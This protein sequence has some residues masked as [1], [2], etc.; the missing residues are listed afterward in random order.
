MAADLFNLISLTADDSLPESS[1]IVW[2][3]VTSNDKTKEPQ[4]DNIMP[5]I[6]PR[7]ELGYRSPYPTD[8]RVIMVNHNDEKKLCTVDVPFMMLS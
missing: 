8:V 4:S 3:I 7:N 6:F 5:I 2:I 1:K